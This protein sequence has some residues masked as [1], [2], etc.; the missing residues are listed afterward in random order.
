MLS[1]HRIVIDSFG[2][3]LENKV[4]EGMECCGLNSGDKHSTP[5]HSAA[6]THLYIDYRSKSYF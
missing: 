1:K 2:E 3:K 5:Q 6:G 4:G